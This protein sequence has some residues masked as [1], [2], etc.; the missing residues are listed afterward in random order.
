[1]I[2]ERQRNVTVL[3]KSYGMAQTVHN[4]AQALADG[5]VDSPAY[6]EM[7]QK[8]GTY[9]SIYA[10]SMNLHNLFIITPEGEIVF[11]TAKESDMNT[12]LLTGPYNKTE[13]ARVFRLTAEKQKIEN[14][15]I[16][17]LRPSGH[18]S[19]FT[20]APVIKETRI[21]GVLVFQL[22]IETLYALTRDYAGLGESGEMVMA[23]LQDEAAV[24]IAPTRH[25]PN[26]ALQRNVKIGSQNAKPI[27]E[28]VSGK[29]GIGTFTDY[30]GETV[31]AAWKY[32]P[33]IK[34]GIVL[35]IDQSEAFAPNHTLAKWFW[36]LG[37]GTFLAVLSVSLLIA[38][39]ISNPIL[40]ITR[41]TT[42]MAAGNSNVR[43]EVRTGD[44]IEA[45]ATSF[46]NMANR[47]DAAQKNSEA[48]NWINA[49]IAGLD[50]VM[51]GE[52]SLSLLCQDIISYIARYVNVQV[53][54]LSLADDDQ[55]RLT[56][57]GSY[58]YKGKQ[59]L[60]REF[61]FGEGLVGQ[62]AREKKRIIIN[63]VPENYL[64]VTSALGEIVPA[65]ILCAPLLY[66][67]ETIG[68]LELGS[69]QSLSSLQLQLLDKT[70]ER[71]AIAIRSARAR[72]KAKTLLEESQVQAEELQAQQ[73]E[74]RV[75]NEEIQIKRDE[76]EEQQGKRMRFNDELGENYSQQRTL[77][78]N[79]ADH[80]NPEC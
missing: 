24:I 39:S 49:G 53:A 57:A 14:L 72:E 11:K 59:I 33:I 78:K 9:L 70:A 43:A 26:A 71:I 80:E 34:L 50:D 19:I 55:T 74:L 66:E 40:N 54:T 52:K 46:N 5:G 25:D 35:K 4:Y 65:S 23:S 37:L 30:R 79:P 42:Q 38:R 21:A 76:L 27:Q 75:A 60:A 36:L 10:T 22:P 69:L 31:I 8:R 6:Q 28:A 3:A 15:N 68:I 63:D 51:R 58:A 13:L 17:S 48:Q 12:N 7:N 67:K 44:E 47:L 56:L 29:T 41:A 64:T 62:A 32:L 61:R 20:A 1:M 45:L 2:A 16:Q 73:E 77:Q 18:L